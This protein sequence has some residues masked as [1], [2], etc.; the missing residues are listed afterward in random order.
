MFP[1]CPMN[2]P[3][4]TPFSR[5]FAS[6]LAL[7]SCCTLVLGLS[8]CSGGDP[9]EKKVDS[10]DQLAFSMWE[11]KVESTLTPEQTE[12]LKAAL[13]E[14]RFH[15]MAAGTAQGS[16][17]IEA[18]LMDSIN[19]KTLRQVILQGLGWKLDRAEEERARL[20]DSLKKNAQMTTRPGDVD[21][22]HYLQDLHERQVNRL[23]AATEEVKKTRE[24]IAAETPSAAPAK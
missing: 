12:D 20:D 8:A 17:G 13:Q 14:G 5:V 10:G 21:S 1:R 16:D 15:I 18:A 3:K 23:A 22:A 2:P 4:G 6:P 9:L 11:S 7:A 24:R 19:G